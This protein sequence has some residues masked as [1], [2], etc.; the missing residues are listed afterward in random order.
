M[1]SARILAIVHARRKPAPR[2]ALTIAAAFLIGCNTVQTQRRTLTDPAQSATIDKKSPF[3]KA[4]MRDGTVYILSRWT[5]DTLAKSVA[6]DGE[7]LD[8]N[9]TIVGTGPHAIPLD[10]V[11]LFETNVVRQHSSV[12]ALAVVTGVSA[13]FTVVCLIDPKTCFGSCPTFYVSDGTRSV[14]QAEGFSASI[15]PALEATD[16]DAL[17]LVRPSSRMLEIRMT[18]E[19]LETHVVRWARVLA[20]PRPDGERVLATQTGDFWRA[21]SLEAPTRCSAAEG[22]CL[23]AVRAFDGAER[24]STADSIDLA[25]RE[26]IDLEFPMIPGDSVGVVIGSR[27][28]LLS[29]FVLYQALA[30]MGRSAGAFLAALQRGDATTRRQAG[31]IG[32]TLGGIEVQALD[33]GGAWVTIGETQETGPLASDVRVVPL[34]GLPSGTT[35]LRLRLTRGHWRIDYLAL[36]RLAGPAQPVHL[37]PVLVR[38]NGAV[39]AQALALLSD[40]SGA[41]TTYPGDEYTLTYQL[42]EDFA[43]YELFL[44]SRG[45]YLE[46]MRQEWMADEM[47]ARAA[48][49]L[50]DPATA[51]RTLAPEFKKREAGME[52]LFWGSRYVRH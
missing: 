8:V 26:V 14:L 32:R 45:Y 44:E 7:R 13:A 15:A 1:R 3:L 11:A 47:P 37:D 43:R 22:D 10:S 28:T 52:A 25:A 16:V 36:A 48:M 18:N 49:M 41:L 51:L 34:L 19:A 2:C 17:Y 42:P 46:W 38:R 6:G 5:V 23:T 27:Q 21:T 33:S 30:Y 50:L 35:R 24:F 4:H 29:T 9:R 39:D 12:G 40:S 31:G 20:V